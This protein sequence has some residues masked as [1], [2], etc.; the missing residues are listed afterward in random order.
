MDFF[1]NKLIQFPLSAFGEP[2][3]QGWLLLDLGAP[4]IQLG[5]CNRLVPILFFSWV[6]Q[7][8]LEATNFRPIEKDSFQ[9][10]RLLFPYKN[11]DIFVT[12]GSD[13]NKQFVMENR[14]KIK[15]AKASD[16]GIIQTIAHQTWPTTFG[17]I[18]SKPQ[19]EY[20]LDMMY[21]LDSLKSQVEE[22]N[23]CFLLAWE[24]DE[25]LGFLSYELN[26][27]G[28]SKTKI[29]K[30]YILLQAQGK[31][32]GKLLIQ[33]AIDTALNEKNSHLLLNV[34]KYNLNAI[35]F[36]EKLGF[37]EASRE[38]I[39]IGNGFLMEDVVMELKLEKNLT[40][41]SSNKPT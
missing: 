5:E 25:V 30:I 4:Y 17:E 34:N 35:R 36:Y 3:H 20:M 40:S 9:I 33:R 28:R 6:C 31:G 8:I 1:R 29:H 23:H 2:I 14:I 16:F 24:E 15:V 38:D 41:E 26:Y 21:S 12:T 13:F 39:S 10:F 27:K 37:Y 32:V 11:Q 22:K 7:H 18:L 19:I